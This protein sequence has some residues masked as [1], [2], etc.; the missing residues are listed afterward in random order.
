V[1]RPDKSG[2][3]AWAWAR[4]IDWRLKRDFRGLW[5]RGPLPPPGEPLLFYANHSSWWDG[6]LFHALC[7]A[8]GREGYCVMEEK[9]LV[10]YPF[11]RRLG[12]FSVRRGDPAS[13]LETMR[14]AAALL[15]EPRAAVMIFPQGVL[16]PG[17]TPPLTLER[18]VEVLARVAKVRC[19]PV[20]LR[21]AFFEDERPDA[22]LEL[23]VPHP[24]AP[25]TRY[26]E[27][28]DTLVASVQSAISLDGF[29]RLRARRAADLVLAPVGSVTRG[30]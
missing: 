16:V 10:R 7:R 27:Q 24:P 28:L 12:A 29:D 18:G 3:R 5:V 26:R 23:G 30:G 2:P 6:F 20:A 19:V 14:C 4:Y 9:N 21:T 8:N 25:L 11:L 13:A 15:K 1:I 17:A 22:L